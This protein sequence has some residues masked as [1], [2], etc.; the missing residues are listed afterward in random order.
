MKLCSPDSPIL[1]TLPTSGGR[2][3]PPFGH[4]P[5]LHSSCRPPIPSLAV[6]KLAFDHPEG[7]FHFGLMLFLV[8]LGAAIKV[9]SR[10]VPALSNKP[11][12]INLA[13]TVASI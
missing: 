12:S 8:E 5:T 1:R 2:F 6:A 7:V 4:L 13:L 3:W 9:A 11:R 10:A